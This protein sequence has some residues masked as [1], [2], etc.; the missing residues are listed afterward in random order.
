[1]EQ[2][3]NNLGYHFKNPALLARA[4]THSSYANERHV[5]TGDNERLEFLGDSVLGFITAEYLFANHRDFPEGELTKLRAYAVCEKSLFSYAEEIGLGNYLKLG[6]GEERT[7]GRTRPSVLSDAFEA[8][9]AAIYLDGGMDEAKKF[10]LRFVV[11]YVEA[12]PTFKDYKTML[13]E[14]VQKNQGETLEYVLVSETGPDHDKCFTVE[15]HL[16]S[17]VIGRG[18]GGSKKKA[19][20]NAAKEA[21][22]LMGI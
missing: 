10:V 18:V 22:E 15:V 2:L 11:P 13:Q 7:G 9:I 6:K 16:N 4:L 1:M 3:Q 21:L 14:V 20:Q 17:N 5:D 19:E 12:K 8:V